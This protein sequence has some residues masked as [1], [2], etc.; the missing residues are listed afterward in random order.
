MGE[1][2][3]LNGGRPV[4]EHPMQLRAFIDQREYELVKEVL[5]RGILSEFRAGPMARKLEDRFA[6]Y[7]DCQF[8][9]AVPSGTTALHLA[10][11]SLGIGPG[12]EVIV[13]PFTF[14]STAS[15]VLQQ[16]A[17]PVFADVDPITF[18]VSP[19][20]VEAAI[21]SRTRAI[22]VVHLFGHPADLLALRDVAT[23]HGLALIEDCAQAHGARYCG[24]RVGAWGDVGCFS[25]YQSKNMTTGE[26]GMLVTN[27][28]VLLRRVRLLKE[29][30]NPRDEGGWYYHVEVGY[31]YQM[32]D[33]QAAV[34]LAQLEKLET[35]TALRRRH[36]HLYSES[37]AGLGLALPQ[38][39]GEIE[40]VYHLYPMLLPPAYAPQRDWFVQALQ[41]ENVL[42]GASYPQS[43]HQNPLF[44]SISR[45]G[46][47][48]QEPIE[49]SDESVPAT[50]DVA[51]RIVTL[52]TDPCLSEE[53]ILDS[54]HA[55]E[56]VWM[57]MVAEDEV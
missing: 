48:S 4:R 2:L 14:V 56:K 40:H 3:A 1:R 16:Y 5:D 6:A 37:L 39:I 11:A 31:N 50:L 43:L 9:V 49:Y 35:M 17:V 26:G 27:D 42:A 46:F 29:C 47:P 33:L 45:G 12:D 25:F 21:T 55:I 20:A 30:G 52:R 32:S 7:H 36:A 34:G 57:H 44:D 38:E 15:A 51:S 22:I 41:A 8:G 24:Q 13:P 23:R 53:D 18:C 19:D 54:C 10:V 28:E